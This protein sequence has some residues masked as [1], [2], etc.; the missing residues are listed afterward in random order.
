MKCKICGQD[1]GWVYPFFNLGKCVHCKVNI[2]VA[3]RDQTELTPEWIRHNEISYK[4]VQN[5]LAKWGLNKK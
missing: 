5:W 1:A 3:L 2:D 4:A